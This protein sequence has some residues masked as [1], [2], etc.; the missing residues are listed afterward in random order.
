MRQKCPFIVLLIVVIL[1]LGALWQPSSVRGAPQVCSSLFFSEYVEGSSYNKGVEIFNGTGENVNLTGY[2]IRI[3]RNGS[4]R[5]DRQIPLTGILANQDVYVVGHSSAVFN[6]DLK[7]GKLDFNGDDGVAL[8]YGGVIIDFIGDTLGDPG[9]QWGAGVVSTKDNTLRRKSWVSIGNSHPEAPFSPEME[10]DGFAKDAFDGLGWHV[11]TCGST[12][13]SITPTLSPTSTPTPSPSA[14]PTPTFTSAPSPSATPTPTFTSTPSP[15]ATPTLTPTPTPV[16]DGVY[17]NEFMPAPFTGDKEYIELYNANPFSVDLSGWLLDDQEGGARPYTLPPGS[18][19]QPQGYLLI[20]RNFGLNNDGDEVRLLAPNGLIRDKMRYESARKGGAWSR[21]GD[22]EPAWTEKYPPSPGAA[23][24][25]AVFTFRGHLYQG[26]PPD[27]HQVIL[28]HN[29]G[30]YGFDDA[31]QI[32]WLKNGY[33]QGDGSYE[34]TFDTAQGLFF[35]YMLRPAPRE[36]MT[37]A[38]VSSPDGLL[39]PPDKIQFDIPA[40]GEHPHNDFWMAN[41]PPTPTPFPSPFVTLNEFMASPKAIDFD[42]D[43][44]ASYLDEYIELFNT[45]D[46]VV[47]LSGWWLDD[48]ENGGSKAWQLPAG[49]VIPPKGFLLF[50][51][52][53]T[54]IALNNDK[55][56][57]RLLAPDGRTEV[58]RMDYAHT[59]VDKPWAR[60]LDGVGDWTDGFPPSPGQPN[61]PPA[62]TPTFTPTPT[63]TPTPTAT[64]TITPTP[65]PTVTP[66]PGGYVVLNELLPAPFAVDF[67]GDGE[68]NL[69]DEY[70]ELYNPQG[71]SVNLEGW[72]LDDRPGGGSRPYIFP[73]GVTIPA[74]GFLLLFRSDTGVALNNDADS[75]WLSDPSGR[76]IDMFQYETT[77][78]DVP[79]ARVED[80][81]GGWTLLFPPSP[82]GPNIPPTPTPTPLPTPSPSEMAL[83]EI[84]PAPRDQDWDHDGQ[85]NY[86]DEWIELLYRGEKAVDLRGW[87]LWRGPLDEKGLPTGRYYQFPAGTIVQPHSLLV[88]FRRQSGLAL[89]ASHGVISLVRPSAKGWQ[90][91]DT[92]AWERSP[93]LDRSF[94]RYPDG[95]GPWL[96]IFVTPGQPNR[97]F[98]TPKPTPSS[99]SKQPASIPLQSLQQ[100]YELAV[101]QVVTVEGVITAPPG[102]FGRRVLM[103]QDD[104][105]GLMVYLRRGRFPALKEGDRVRVMGFLQDFHGQRELV[106]VSAKGVALLGVRDPLTPQFFRTGLITE[107]LMGMLVQ[108]AGRV[109]R[110]EKDAFW[111]DDGSGRILVQRPKYAAWTMPTLTPDGVVSVTGIVSRFEDKL[112]VQVRSR[113]EISPPPDVLPVTGGP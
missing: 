65:S 63:H 92:F 6:A 87:R 102:V 68:A 14:T 49:S 22:G 94:S 17:I 37:W 70:I 32:R 77:R 31:G 13:S 12:P 75:V 46:Q 28:D 8:V 84:L 96:R 90:V 69:L 109:I 29:I 26:H 21:M 61:L 95:E 27:R 73:S 35:H 74:H 62:N 24:V 42:G 51:R 1:V 15:S 33:V 89:P 79:W 72:Q 110:V 59:K 91:V 66:A 44:E 82:G 55:D 81:S 47:D 76:V 99:R 57:V 105:S 4:D 7:T 60:V 30:L 107:A 78:R 106:L 88:I 43:G 45:T 23:N 104:R 34:I 2:E 39:L 3:Y 52:K 83:N 19:L 101:G 85:A 111:I 71:T 18:M 93:G 58:D 16:P 54:G 50:F 36:G 108:T 5:F 64:P 48:R 100:A 9:T 41:L 38:G 80:G 11:A 20:R 53:Q 67:N 10:W 98:P 113:N 56:S 25:P 97:P 40:S 112:Y 103:I 86:A